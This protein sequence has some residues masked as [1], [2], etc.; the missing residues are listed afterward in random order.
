MQAR[1]TKQ[2]DGT[3]EI[4]NSQRKPG[5]STINPARPAT[6]YVIS[7]TTPYL[8]ASF[9]YIDRNK[10][11]VVR[12][13]FTNYAVVRSCTE[14]LFGLFREEVVWILVRNFNKDPTVIATAEQA[15]KDSLPH[16]SWSNF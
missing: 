12:S 2:A 15:V 7:S 11:E 10:Y 13:D 1:Y 9:F 4:R 3:V 6:A 8:M 5:Q 16:Y 14:Y